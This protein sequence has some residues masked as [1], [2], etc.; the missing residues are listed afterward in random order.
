MNNHNSRFNNSPCA[1]IPGV[2]QPRH[3]V[4]RWLN[5]AAIQAPA[6]PVHTGGTAGP[7]HGRAAEYLAIS[8]SR[9]VQS[10]TRE[11]M[12]CSRRHRRITAH[13]QLVGLANQTPACRE[14]HKDRLLLP[15]AP[16][17]G[18]QL[19]QG[20]STTSLAPPHRPGALQQ[21]HR[22]DH[23]HQQQRYSRNP[24]AAGR[25]HRSRLA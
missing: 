22:P 12:P 15:L 17:A 20:P 25:L 6:H 2:F 8:G 3:G 7:R 5:S 16:P 19:A 4:F 14:I 1:I 10:A 9:S 13:G 23:E 11:T 18:D 21:C 24:T